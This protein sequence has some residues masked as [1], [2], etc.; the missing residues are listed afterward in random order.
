MQ[1]HLAQEQQKLVKA[2]PEWKDEKVAEMDK[3]NI[4]TYAK[5]Y[6]FN[7]QELNNATDHRAILM[8]R[9]AMMFDDLQA[10]KPLV[11]KKVKKAPKMTKSGKKLTTQ[12]S[13]N[14]G[15]VDKAYNK[16]KSTGSMDSAVDYL[17]QKSN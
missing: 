1:K 11:K 6:G 2:I 10:K 13:L 12:K 4:V 17:L 9:K 3:R 14:A 15:K 7:D 16:L 5:R 8:L